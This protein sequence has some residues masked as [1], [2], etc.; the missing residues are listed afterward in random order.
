MV[1]PVEMVFV[2]PPH[3][4]ESYGHA[5]QT[6]EEKLMVGRSG[7]AKLSNINKRNK[8]TNDVISHKANLDKAERIKTEGAKSASD[9]FSRRPTQL[10]NYWTTKNVKEEEAAAAA[11]APAVAQPEIKVHSAVTCSSAVTDE[12]LPAPRIPIRVDEGFFVYYYNTYFQNI[13]PSLL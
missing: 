10:S 13:I 8:L 4:C 6:L 12:D 1:T 2:Y 7:P 11:A 3:D 5:L 9:P